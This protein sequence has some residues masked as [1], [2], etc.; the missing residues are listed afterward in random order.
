LLSGGQAAACFVCFDPPLLLGEI[1]VYNAYMEAQGVVASDQP[2]AGLPH[3][4]R[5]MGHDRGAPPFTGLSYAGK[6]RSTAT[7]IPSSCGSGETVASF[8]LTS[9]DAVKFR[10]ALEASRDR[11]GPFGVE[12]VLNKTR[13]EAEDTIKTVSVCAGGA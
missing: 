7:R 12:A 5:P 4:Y 3:L 11:G 8:P 10:T 6:P 9:V 13:I 2:G 1:A